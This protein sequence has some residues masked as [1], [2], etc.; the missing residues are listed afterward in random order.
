MVI[1]HTN[2][3]I[4]ARKAGGLGVISMYAQVTGIK[5]VQIVRTTQLIQ[6]GCPDLI[7]FC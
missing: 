1:A 3:P 2:N 5:A 7:T 4:T 6:W